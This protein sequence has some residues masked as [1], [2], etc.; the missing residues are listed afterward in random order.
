PSGDGIYDTSRS[1]SSRLRSSITDL[2]RIS[3][4]PSTTHTSASSGERYGLYSRVGS[5]DQQGNSSTERHNN[6]SDPA[7][8]SR[9]RQ[10]LRSSL[11]RETRRLGRATATSQCWSGEIERYRQ[12]SIRTSCKSCRK[13]ERTRTDECRSQ[14]ETSANGCRSERNG[15]ETS[16]IS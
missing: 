11:C 1:R 8:L 3:R 12:E 7:S 15:T 2:R 10:S 9:F 14:R 13:A 6:I 5:R 4:P 16:C